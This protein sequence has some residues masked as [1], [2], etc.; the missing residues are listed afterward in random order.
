MLGRVWGMVL[1]H[2]APFSRPLG[3]GDAPA[4]FRLI[5]R[6]LPLA[7]GSR[8]RSSSGSQ[9]SA[10]AGPAV[11][12]IPMGLEG[13]LF[14]DGAGGQAEQLER[15]EGS[16]ALGELR[17]ACG[18]PDSLVRKVGALRGG[19]HLSGAHKG[20]GGVG[21]QAHRRILVG[22]A[23]QGCQC[24][25]GTSGSPAAGGGWKEEWHLRVFLA[26]PSSG[27]P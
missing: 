10:V 15:S 14:K 4:P 22:S 24:V 2:G 5:I 6:W 19:M 9:S 12:S 23:S 16:G 20:S 11:S 8:G 25:R 1:A 3:T 26:A 13:R 7:P 21:A 17:V 27:R 18:R